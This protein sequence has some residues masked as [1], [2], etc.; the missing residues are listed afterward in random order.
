MKI[1]VMRTYMV[2]SLDQMINHERREPKLRYHQVQKIKLLTKRHTESANIKRSLIFS[3]TSEDEEYANLSLAELR[4][5]HEDLGL[6][7]IKPLTMAKLSDLAQVIRL[8]RDK[9][10]QECLAIEASADPEEVKKAKIS[11]LKSQFE[12]DSAEINSQINNKCELLDELSAKSTKVLSH[13]AR[14]IKLEN[15]QSDQAEKLKGNIIL[16]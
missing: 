5:M 15:R 4:E 8:L 10:N 2:H 7:Q 12:I 13:I 11:E 14:R 6:N 1:L 3:E 16:L 9:L